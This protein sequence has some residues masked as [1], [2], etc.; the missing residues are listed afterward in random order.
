[1]MLTT[2][3]DWLPPTPS[4][5][6]LAF[7]ALARAANWDCIA[8]ISLE[9]HTWLSSRM[10]TLSLISPTAWA[11]L[12]LPMGS[13]IL[14]FSRSIIGWKRVINASRV[15][16]IGGVVFHKSQ[17]HWTVSPKYLWMEVGL[18]IDVLVG[19]GAA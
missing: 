2:P 17:V 1:M 18:V 11:W 7:T 12:A 4:I 8:A 15:W 10:L 9:S 16:S 3:F 6:V 13:V 19:N 5:V 14:G